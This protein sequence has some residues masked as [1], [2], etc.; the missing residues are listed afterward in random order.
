MKDKGVFISYY[1]DMGHM[2]TRSKEFLSE[3]DNI[4][5]FLDKFKYEGYVCFV[6]SINNKEYL[7]FI[8]IKKIDTIYTVFLGYINIE[9]NQNIF[10]SIELLINNANYF[11]SIEQ[12]DYLKNKHL[13]HIEFQDKVVK[14]EENFKDISWDN[15]AQLVKNQLVIK[16]DIS[17]SILQSI[18]YW[19]NF[20]IN[21]LFIS[22]LSLNDLLE[23]KSV[24]NLE[25]KLNEN[26]GI[27]LE[28]KEKE[29]LKKIFDKYEKDYSKIYT[30][31]DLN[32]S[33]IHEKTIKK[34]SHMSEDTILA[35]V[36]KRDE[37][38]VFYIENFYRFLQQEKIKASDLYKILILLY[39]RE[40]RDQDIKDFIE[41]YIKKKIILVLES[42]K[43]EE[44]FDF[45]DKEFKNISVETKKRLARSSLSNNFL[46][47]MLN[48]LEFYKNTCKE[49][50]LKCAWELHRVFESDNVSESLYE[51]NMNLIGQLINSL[52]GNKNG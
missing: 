18:K 15:I 47:M 8:Q 29:N 31:F 30:S 32:L 51:K 24:L 28:K 23:I 10:V 46:E 39:Q 49:N 41:K 44:V 3:L 12:Q 11:Q 43:Y 34:D 42:Q 40:W 52:G 33:K 20:K 35:L 7:I 27:D 17:L 19:D 22:N 2:K 4:K 48:V 1:G 5:R 21:N 6:K 14:I 9:L 26:T 38:A 45:L 13:L 36:V 37:D 50:R 16:K 25:N